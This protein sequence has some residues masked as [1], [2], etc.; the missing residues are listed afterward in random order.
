MLCGVTR[1]ASSFAARLVLLAALGRRFLRRPGLPNSGPET[2]LKQPTFV[3]SA[4][5]IVEIS[6]SSPLCP[7]LMAARTRLS[8]G[9]RRQA[10][11]PLGPAATMQAWRSCS[12]QEGERA[13]GG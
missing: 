4:V 3:G 9:D 2:S 10:T 6:V 12:D 8:T 1:L 11:D 7:Q 5:E 13:R